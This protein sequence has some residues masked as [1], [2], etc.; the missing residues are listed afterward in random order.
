MNLFRAAWMSTD[1]KIAETRPIPKC[2]HVGFPVWSF[3][4]TAMNPVV[5]R[6]D[7]E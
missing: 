5:D 2:V 4:A 1:S 7:D 3:A 6:F